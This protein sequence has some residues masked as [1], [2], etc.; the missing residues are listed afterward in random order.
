MIHLDRIKFTTK[1]TFGQLSS[2]DPDILFPLC[3]T[4]ERPW[5]NNQHGISCIPTGIYQVEQY[6]SPTKGDVWQLLNV[7]NRSNIEIHPANFASQLEGCIAPGDAIGELE[8]MSAVLHSRK[9][10]S[11]LKSCLP[12]SFQLTITGG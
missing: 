8:G 4:I 2:D 9:T 1:E 5:L 3:F 6:N 11:M 10:F 12:D 7:P